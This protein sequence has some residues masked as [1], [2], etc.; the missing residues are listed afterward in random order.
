MAV[1]LTLNHWVAADQRVFRTKKKYIRGA[2]RGDTGIIDGVI[3]EHKE[4]I[5]YMLM[6]CLCVPQSRAIKAEEAIEE[7]RA[8]SFYTQPLSTSQITQI[9]SRHVRFHPTKSKR[10]SEAKEIFLKTSFWEELRARYELFCAAND[11]KREIILQGTRRVLMKAVNGMG[12]KL[13]SHFMRNVGMNGLAILDVH[14][15]DGLNKR[16]VIDIE[17]LSPAQAEYLDIEQKMK[18]YAEQVGIFLDELDLLLWSQKTG[19]VFK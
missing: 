8:K 14:V 18:D 6:F 13:A 19:Y 1:T 15:I 11:E 12:M 10:L 7:L 3:E 9:L 17:K 16:G 4:D 5:F 2:L